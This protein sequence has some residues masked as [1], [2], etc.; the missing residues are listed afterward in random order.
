M[1]ADRTVDSTLYQR[2]GELLQTLIRFN[3][4]NPPG[5]EADCI[6]YINGLL[7]GA[8]FEPRLFASQPE[9]PNLLTRLPGRGQ[10][11]PLLLYAHV[12]V[13][14]AKNQAWQY[15]PFAGQVVDGCLWGR[16]A[17][18]DKNGVT[19][20]LCA[21]LRARAEGL[22]PPGDVIL[23]LLSDE[24]DGG[25]LGARYMVE[26]HPEQFS[27]VRYA[28]GEVGGFSL[29]LAGR[30]FYPIMVNEKSFCMLRLTVSGPA[31]HAGTAVV[32]GSTTARLG[33]LLIRL[34][35]ARLPVHLTPVV[36]AMLATLSAKA[37]FP[38]GAAL[39]LLLRPSLTDGLL[40]LLGPDGIKLYPLFHNTFNITSLR[41]GEQVASTPARATV[42]IF[43]SLLPGYT[44]AD[45]V[46]ELQ[47]IAGEGVE[48]EV[49]YP[50]DGVTLTP[51]LGLFDTLGDILRQAD[52]HGVPTQL[53]LT[54][55][56]DGRHF[57][58]LGIQTYGFQ[59]L[60][61]PPDIDLATLAH[62]ADERVTLEGLEF[63]VQAQFQALQR[64]GEL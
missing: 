43:A 32:H 56:T 3:T 49:T 64:F 17:L 40:R 19:I 27:G 18:D 59:P 22:V 13:V 15:P 41:G 9:R 35:Q 37:P 54:G 7:T 24:E 60:K 2:P 63:G 4:T 6:A 11:P 21:L 12:D 34:D 14:A 36:R 26:N 31:Y 30:R 53:L 5:N 39:G 46:A 38:A 28:L 47:P 20:S 48:F 16:G 45:L 51:D 52:P 33:A 50:G 61:L 55:P 62:A 57:A 8:G 23:A 1:F 44:A 58:R 10:A 29:Y 25:K 42:D